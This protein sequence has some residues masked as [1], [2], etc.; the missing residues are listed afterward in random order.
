MEHSKKEREIELI[1]DAYK[2]CRMGTYAIDCI[3]DK[4]EDGNFKELVKKQN[5]SYLDLTKQIRRLALNLNHELTDI[6]F[7]AKGMSSLSIDMKTMLNKETSH[8]AQMLIDGTTMG[9]TT[10]IKERNNNEGL[11]EDLLQVSDKLISLMEKF[12][13]SLKEFL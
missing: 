4:I 1:D 7:M 6:N 2:T 8:L 10:M 5:K 12:V 13:E 11:N 3:M 9:I